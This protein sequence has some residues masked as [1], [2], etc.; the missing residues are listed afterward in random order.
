M[1]FRERLE[2]AIEKGRSLLCIGLDP[3]LERFPEG[4]ARDAQGIVAF[5]RAIVEATADLV[6]A[7]KPNLAFY[8]AH[9]AAGIAAL[10]ETRRSIPPDIPVILDAKL[11]DIASTSAAYARAVFETLGFDAVTVHP[12]LGSE[13]LEP[14]FA[15]ADRGVFVLV[16]TSNPGAVELQDA[17]VGEAG[18]PLFLWLADRVR[19]WNKR[20]GNLGLVVGATYPVDLALVRQRCPDLPVL[21]PGVGAQGGDLE[22]TV[23]AALSE[24]SGPL[25]VNVAR[26]VLY[27]S[28]G[29]DFAEAAREAARR[30]RDRIE[31]V[32]SEIQKR[33][34]GHP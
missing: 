4:I 27:A 20:F 28:S 24:G 3:D 11:G 25:L 29:P 22:E 30:L 12:Y 14:F 31:A 1:S 7:Y 16:R 18:E 34:A 23:R 17:P 2:Q 13:A 9:G 10:A 33:T 15:Y 8:L 21:A 5:N 19:E 26:S 6:C 32:R